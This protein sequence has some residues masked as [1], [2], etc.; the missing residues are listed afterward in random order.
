MLTL[1]IQAGGE[2]LRMGRD[3][4][5]LPFLGKPLISRVIDRLSPLADEIIVM[6][7]RPESYRFLGL[8]I[9]LDVKPGHGALGGLYTAIVSAK[10]PL[11]AVVAC[12]MPFACLPLFTLARDILIK[13]NVDVVIPST[14]DGVEPFH[15]VYRCET[16][17]PAVEVALDSYRT[18]LTSWLPL[19]KVITLNPSQTAKLD[20]RGLAF[21]NINTP[22]DFHR[23]EQRA[24]LLDQ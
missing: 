24:R 21:W 19:V 11:V 9:F 12:D 3:K 1:A 2:S 20:P 4:A 15:A 23:A 17:L 16:C 7:N 5:L 14:G 8:P 6:A 13:E 10:N 18:R 22:E